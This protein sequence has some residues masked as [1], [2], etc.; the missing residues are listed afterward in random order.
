MPARVIGP[1]ELSPREAQVI[2]DEL[3][4]RKMVMTVVDREEIFTRAAIESVLTK[5]QSALRGVDTRRGGMCER[6]VAADLG[7][8]ET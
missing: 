3:E 6:M 2:V 7:M 4:A 1:I 8:G 5:V